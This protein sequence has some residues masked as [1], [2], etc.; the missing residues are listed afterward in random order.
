MSEKEAIKKLLKTKKTSTEIKNE[1]G[2]S[3]AKL[4]KVSRELGVKLVERNK[5]IKK[6]ASTK[7]LFFS[8]EK[9]TKK[10]IKQI[11]K[12]K[13]NKEIC[14]KYD[15][16]PYR[17]SKVAKVNN[18]TIQRP[19][20][21]DEFRHEDI[22]NDLKEG[23]MT[24][25]EI[26]VKYNVTKQRI[27]QFAK[28][29]DL[30]RNINSMKAKK[31]DIER[32]ENDVKLGLPYEELRKKYNLTK[33]RV[34]TLKYHG[35]EGNLSARY[36][37]VRNEEIVSQYKTKTAKSVLKM[38]SKVLNDPSRIRG[39]GSIYSIASKSGFK[40]Y[41]KIGDRHKG[42]VFEDK[43]VIS[44]I[45]RYRHRES[46]SF[47]QI[48]EKLNERGFIS[49]MGKPYTEHNTRSKYKAIIKYKA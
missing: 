36:R 34:S 39:E 21:R 11:K 13:T 14:V 40:K 4:T 24:Y 28:E 37:N 42:G 44:L 38:S 49:P 6:G 9:L 17:V 22:L 25:I 30:R 48:A 10:I 45:K 1:L 35:F 47:K 18:L 19:R 41:P 43:K 26:G 29:Y 2:V 32:I 5:L 31:K 8:E 46:W 16:K 3:S 23:K 27:Y 12:G 15:V 33:S 7:V 20:R